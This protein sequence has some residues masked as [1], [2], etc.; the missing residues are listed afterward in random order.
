[1]TALRQIVSALLDSMGAGHT[2][3]F[4]MYV[5][6]PATRS[7]ATSGEEIECTAPT[8]LRRT[9]RFTASRSWSENWVQH[10][11]D[12]LIRSMAAN[13]FQPSRYR[14]V[15]RNLLWQQLYGIRHMPI[16][17]LSPTGSVGTSTELAFACHYCG[18]ILPV[19]IMEVDHQ[20]PQA[21]GAN[22]AA[23]KCFRAYGLTV[24]RPAGNKGAAV[25]GGNMLQPVFPAASIT[26]RAT[27]R[28]GSANRL[29][30]NRKGIIL[31]SL[32]HT[33]GDGPQQI[34]RFTH[35]FCN[36]APSCAHC[37]GPGGKGN[38]VKRI[39]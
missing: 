34:A 20:H 14:D 12:R 26:G 2:V 11:L 15:K 25:A 17:K 39:V 19:K 10:D 21:G 28:S 18:C 22:L 30:L 33:R 24:G 4:P 13:L 6:T 31:A 37:N 5:F 32:L 9:F 1:M 38:I 7:F 3:R 29:T 23:M 16:L 8:A 27:T 36:L 35:H